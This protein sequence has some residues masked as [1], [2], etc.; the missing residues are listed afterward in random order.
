MRAE[1]WRAGTCAHMRAKQVRAGKSTPF[2]CCH[3]QPFFLCHYS[4]YLSLGIFWPTLLVQCWFHA[5]SLYQLV[6]SGPAG[7]F[8]HMSASLLKSGKIENSG[9]YGRNSMKL[10]PNFWLYILPLVLQAAE[11]QHR[12]LMAWH[13]VNWGLTVWCRPP[14]TLHDQDWLGV[15]K[16]VTKIAKLAMS[17]TYMCWIFL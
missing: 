16:Y 8:R 13:A 5:G 11:A 14:D 3:H 1:R 10:R 12:R 9:W 15:S 2:F 4:T 7:S 17:K 6:E